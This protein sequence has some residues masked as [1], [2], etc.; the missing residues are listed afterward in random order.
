MAAEILDPLAEVRYVKLS[1]TVFDFGEGRPS[2]HLR[3]ISLELSEQAYINGEEDAGLC[4]EQPLYDLSSLIERIAEEVER[5]EV[6][7]LA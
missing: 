6:T 7:P 4:L 5:L 2:E 1:G 3:A